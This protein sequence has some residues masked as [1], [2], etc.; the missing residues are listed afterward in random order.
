V[1]Q[2]DRTFAEFTPRRA[3]A[4]RRCARCGTKDPDGVVGISLRAY[5]HAAPSQQKL[6]GGRTLASKSRS[7]CEGCAIEVYEAIEKQMPQ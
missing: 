6:K 1:S 5:G 3:T 4:E 7:M 2:D